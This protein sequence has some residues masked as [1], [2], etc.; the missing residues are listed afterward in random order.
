FFLFG[1]VA[2]GTTA[3]SRVCLCEINWISRRKL[4]VRPV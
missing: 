3:A 1:L 4:S 2:R